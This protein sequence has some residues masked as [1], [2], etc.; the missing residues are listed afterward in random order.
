MER[1]A[2]IGFGSAG[3]NAL[4]AIRES[5][6]D[7]RVDIY[8]D[9]V[10]P[11]YNPMLTTYYIKGKI[12][13]EAMFPFGSLQ[14]IRERYE[15][16]VITESPVV[17]FDAEKKT[18]TLAD[19]R[20]NSY[21]KVLIA[22]GAVP[23]KLPVGDL[24][25]DRIFTMRTVDDARRLKEVL[26]Q[27]K[28]RK[29]LVVGASWV[30]IKVVEIAWTLGIECVLSDLAPHIFVASAFEAASEKCEEYL[31]GENID[32]RFGVKTEECKLENGQCHIHFSDGSETF[33]DLVVMCVGIRANMSF[34]KPD[35]L[36]AGR[37]IT[38]DNNMCTSVPDV[39][40]A[41]D[42][43]EGTDL[44]TGEK[45]NI[46]LWANSAAQ[47]Y[48]AGR[49]MAGRPKP[50]EGNILHNITHFLNYN[51]VSFGDKNGPGERR[52]LLDKGD[53]YIEALIHDDKIYCINILSEFEMSGVVKNC[54]M[55]YFRKNA[56]PLNELEIGVLARSGYPNELIR[57]LGGMIQ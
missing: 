49:A 38:V 52:V 2:I 26:D 40:A 4:K 54:I 35:Q 14:D 45:R 16:N 43:A 50:L 34:V 48:C 33:V 29:I 13:Y 28:T 15:C 5:G 51:F 1:Y 25:A 53:R 42:V 41:G 22:T 31:R 36:M 39:Y 10:Y 24:P 30:G 3:Y 32:L 12:P 9:T 6:D 8:S 37:A 27:G 57:I 20:V 23:V 18:V 46:G 7:A 11:P 47:G 44:I 19:G 17:S 21:D 56:E 55:K